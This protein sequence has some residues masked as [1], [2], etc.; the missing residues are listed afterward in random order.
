MKKD[1]EYYMTLP[2]KI[3]LMPSPEGGYGVEMPELPGCI[4]QGETV[5]EAMSMI[6]DAKR[7]WI[8]IALADQLPIPEPVR[9]GSDYSGKFVVRVPRSL[10][11][12]LVQKARAENVSLNQLATYLLSSGVS[13]PGLHTLR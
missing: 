1:F 4:S 2:Y 8:E 13:K 12:E 3:V 5:V 7:A 11:Q 6:E 9:G 10:H